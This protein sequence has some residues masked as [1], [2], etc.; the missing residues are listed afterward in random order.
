MIQ[1]TP[2]ITIA[3]V[4][5]SFTIIP[6]LYKFLTSGDKDGERS[7]K[8]LDK[9]KKKEK[10]VPNPRPKDGKKP[11]PTP[12]PPPKRLIHKDS[13]LSCSGI[14]APDEAAM[15]ED[16]VF[17]KYDPYDSSRPY[18]PIRLQFDRDEMVLDLSRMQGIDLNKPVIPKNKRTR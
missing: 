17:K 13:N 5:L 11:N 18:T 1:F 14:L 12:T 15:Y 9:P 3:L 6:F 10:Y 7:K 16:S 8:E 4:G 2:E